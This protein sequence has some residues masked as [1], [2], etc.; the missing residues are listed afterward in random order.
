MIVNNLIL[1]STQ[2]EV[3][4]YR[5]L[6]ARVSNDASLGVTVAT[7]A[8]LIQELWDVW[9]TGEQLVTPASRKMIIKRLLL[10]QERWVASSGTVD[11]LASFL[12]DAIA[13]VD[14]DFA[15][16]HRA[17]FSPTDADIVAFLE[18]YQRALSEASLLEPAQALRFMGKYVRYGTTEVR[19]L[20]PLKSYQKDFL[21]EISDEVLAFDLHSQLRTGHSI[22]DELEVRE[23]MS[24]VL[25]ATDSKTL[26]LLNP[27]GKSASA[28]MVYRQ[29][30]ASPHNKVLL[31]STDPVTLFDQL[32]PQLADEGFIVSLD[33]KS[34][35]KETL[36]GVAFDSV[37]ALVDINHDLAMNEMLEAA[38]AYV[39]SPFARISSENRAFLERTFREN[40]A[41]SREEIIA[42]LAS[43]SPSFDLF[44]EL[45]SDADAD[46]L[47]D[48]FED[49]LNKL[50]LE[51]A[52][53]DRE[54][55]ILART[56][57]LYLEA[58]ALGIAPLEFYDLVTALSVP[59]KVT[60]TKEDRI[61]QALCD[62]VSALP[63]LEDDAQIEKRIL[64]TT[65]DQAA[66]LPVDCCDLA[67]LAG[68]DSQNFN[69]AEDRSTLTQ[70]LNKFGL[71]VEDFERSVTECKFANICNA[72]T[73]AVVFEYPVQD[74]KGDPIYPA[75]FLEEF[76]NIKE[77]LGSKLE[78]IRMGEELFDQSLA[79][80]TP[81]SASLLAEDPVVR[82]WLS[83]DER[84]EL[85]T[86]HLDSDGV[87][88]MVVSPSS[89]EK[90]RSC[91][92]SWFVERKLHLE[93]LQENFGP[94]EKGTFAHDLFKRFYDEW[95]TQGKTRVDNHS[96]EEA[97]DLFARLFDEEASL[98]E[99]KEPGARLVATAEFE[100]LELEQLKAQML[101]SLEF[102]KDIFPS[103]SV[104]AHE[105]AIEPEDQIL[106]GGAII[107]GRVDR[108]D[109]NDANSFVV[110][111]YKGSTLGYA[112]GFDGEGEDEEFTSPDKVQALIYAQALRRL[113]PQLQPKA[114]LYLGY[115]AKRPKDLLAG[116]FSETMP[117]VLSYSTRSSAVSG[118]FG[119]YLDRVE[120]DL[121]KT[122]AR[123]ESGDI[124]PDPRSEKACE[125]CPVL[126]CE[127][128]IDGSI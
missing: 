112:A 128:R 78:P 47:L 99:S 24:A 95:A 107:R 103:Y 85:F 8:S 80:T 56:R 58:R 40:R 127:A 105:K 3:I 92:Y 104:F 87:S 89:I 37:R 7:P 125:H 30:T 22:S 84:Q 126:Y 124:A 18:S 59:Y 21:R 98:Q 66:T 75:F 38:I 48:A 57:D 26:T 50:T 69:G 117:E 116:S 12:R 115:K 120:D 71:P 25:D 63:F 111:D 67:I 77:R 33:S 64:F 39:N 100:R 5:K 91:P 46:L 101:Q 54:R 60:V 20:E 106:Y 52:A 49:V 113:H 122:I 110:I 74:F 41:V 27:A 114:A 82:G 83:D 108:V 76:L 93:D 4:A 16:S 123:M 90:Y 1:F 29:I 88:R 9:G 32:A 62:S 61:Q 55:A 31:A 118:D 97:K 6:R 94:L 70:F 53:R 43:N 11:L 81:D 35:F 45:L 102:Q 86:Y 109:I 10:D 19:T 68:L 73:D 44:T 96:I 65:F 2:S 119:A 72:A 42:Q 34:R 14:A 51:P 15:A 79:L 23:E 121:S 36:F 17:S 13:Y 28:Y